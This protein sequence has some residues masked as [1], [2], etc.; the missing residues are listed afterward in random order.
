M[1]ISKMRHHFGSTQYIN[2][3]FF[4][5]LC[6]MTL[7]LGPPS[8]GKTTLLMALAGRL[9]QGL[10]VEGK[11]RY[12]GLTLEEFVPQRTSS[13]I[14][15]TDV[16]VGEMTVKETL[17][18]SARCQGVGSRYESLAE[19]DRKEKEAG[20]F[21]EV[22][23]DLFMKAT[24]MEGV[25]SNIITDYIIKILGLEIC[26]DTVV[27]NQMIRGISG[28]QKKRLTTGK[29]L[30]LMFNYARRDYMIITTVCY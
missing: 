28:G 21:Q 7:L 30:Y 24:S 17:D 1:K 2:C 19:V 12:N 3:S 11:V 29:Q 25:E 8:S 26:R 23:V 22:D 18:F 10:M 15:Q 13:Y 16:H 27:G 9:D 4:F 6:R 14:S 20:I 5:F